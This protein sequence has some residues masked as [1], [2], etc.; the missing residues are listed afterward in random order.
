M[1]WGMIRI[2]AINYDRE[3]LRR[4]LSSDDAVVKARVEALWVRT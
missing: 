3:S 1:P 4:A 2:R